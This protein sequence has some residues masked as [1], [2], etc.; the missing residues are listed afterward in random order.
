MLETQKRCKK[1]ARQE[2]AGLVTGQYHRQ[3]KNSIKEAIV[4]EMNVVDDQ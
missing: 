3:H 1:K 2:D 4:L